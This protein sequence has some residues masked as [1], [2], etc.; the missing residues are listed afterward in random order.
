[1]PTSSPYIWRLL[2]TSFQL[3]ASVISWVA[4]LITKHYTSP[5]AMHPPNWRQA[6]MW[7]WRLVENGNK[8]CSA[9]TDDKHSCI[10]E[11]ALKMWNRNGVSSRLTASPSASDLAPVRAYP[12]LSLLVVD[13]V[14]CSCLNH[15]AVAQTGSLELRSENKAVAL[16]WLQ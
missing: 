13:W 5:N 15:R 3:S 4:L 12:L 9:L 2:I 1:M 16:K 11:W 6:E 8:L 10:L 14:S 7:K